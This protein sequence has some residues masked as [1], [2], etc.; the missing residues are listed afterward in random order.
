MRL[1]RRRVLFGIGATALA[2]ACGS[3]DGLAPGA[4]GGDVVVPD[5]TGEPAEVSD[6][7]SG[8]DTTSGAE[9]VSSEAD[10]STGLDASEVVRPPS[11]PADTELIAPKTPTRSFYVT[12]CCGTPEVDAATWS[13]A[14]SDRGTPLASITLP[15]LEGL[16]AQER[17][18]TLECIGTGPSSQKISN[19]VW[20][21]RSLLDVFAAAGV[22]VPADAT[23]M[24][25]TASDGFSTGLPITD[26]ALPVWLVWK[27][28]GLPI[29][30]EHGFP[31]RLLV[32]GRYGM[33]N[34]KWITGIEF[35]T[36]HYGGYWESQGW[37]DA[38]PYRPNTFIRAPAGGAE[39]GAGTVRLVGT[40]FA[41]RDPVTTVEVR[42]D[43]GAWAPAV[44]DYAPGPDVWALWHFDWPTLPGTHEL[45]A[46]CTTASGARSA[47]EANPP[48][49]LTGYAGSMAIT[50]TIV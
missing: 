28:D 50:V 12:S 7:V 48:F 35:L 47:E 40:A 3:G 30:A 18:H 9:E 38:A 31:A 10:A 46:R 16:V 34:P 15:F 32:P 29:P 36:E 20:S 13:I 8:A 45:Q 41:G 1:S 5:A 23:Y 21:G 14:V 42:V 25:F 19:T 39:L 17:E 2:G 26:L 4:G 27:M 37:S 49:D 6:A 43:G 44:L 33:K 11:S 22:T 24:K